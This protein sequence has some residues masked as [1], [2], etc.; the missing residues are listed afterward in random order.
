MKL[1][2]FGL[3]LSSSWG[4]GHATLWRGLV[5]A[6]ARDGHAVVFF[7]RDV[8]YY[9][10][11]RDLEFTDGATLILYKTWDAVLAL[12]R[13]HLAEADAAL[14]T[15]YCPDARAAASLIFEERAASLAVFYDLD[16]PVT[17]ARLDAGEE[18]SYLPEEG[19]AD[20]DL[21]LSYAGGS[22]LDQLR[23]R[24]GARRVAPLYGHADPQLHH[25][26]SNATDVRADLSYLGTYAPDR[27]R[28]LEELFLAPA[29]R[30]PQMRFVIGGAGYPQEF[31]WLSNIWFVQHV[32]PPDHP[33]FFS[34]SRLTL[35]VTRADMVATGYCP[36]GR[37]FEAAACGTP[38]ISDAWPGIETFYTPGEEIVIAS[39]ADQVSA[40]LALSDSELARIGRNAREH[41]LDVHTSAHRARELISLLEEVAAARAPHTRGLSY[42]GNHSSGG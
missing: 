21:V 7:E 19:L 37:L 17:L 35:N 25:P 30:H 39:S 5:R 1:I 23:Q 32:P 18:V 13:G 2:I 11:H 15:S 9:A 29:R 16:T 8:D 28:A 6:L 41:T 26:V 20:F 36:S 40:A 42:V 38:V 14:V 27:Q 24:L 3:T 12:A 10:R 34:S 22:A 33:V 31:P 4:N